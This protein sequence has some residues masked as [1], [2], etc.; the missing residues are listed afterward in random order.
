[1]T[2]S[3]C[4]ANSMRVYVRIAINFRGRCLKNFRFGSFGHSQ[5]IGFNGF[6]D[7]VTNHFKIRP[8]QKMSDIFLV[9]VKKVVQT[10]NVVSFF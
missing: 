6:D 7:V 4:S 10:E 2:T 8:T 1:M 5:D 9:P 3:A